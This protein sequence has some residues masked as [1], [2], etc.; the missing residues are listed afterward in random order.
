MKVSAQKIIASKEEGKALAALAQLTYSTEKHMCIHRHRHGRGFYY[1]KNGKK[2]SNKKVLERIKKLVIPPAWN[3]VQICISEK[4]HLQ[5]AGKDTKDRKVYLYHP[6]WMEL[7]N[8][9]KFFRMAAFGE[10]LPKIRRQV[11]KDLNLRGMPQR[12][13]LALVIRLMEETHIRIGNPEYASENGSFGLTTLRSRH[14]E[15][16]KNKITFEF[17]GKKGKQQ[18]VD[19]TDKKLVKLVNRCEE[20]PGWEVFKYFDDTHDKQTIDSGMVNNYIREIAGENFSAKDFRTWSGSILFFEHLLKLG[21]A[22]NEKLNRKNINEAV[23]VAAEAL[24]NTKSV[25]E[26]YYIHP[27][28]IRKYETGELKQEFQKVAKTRDNKYMSKTE[29]VLLAIYRDFE[30]KL[31]KTKA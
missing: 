14:L 4:G 12:K 26:N 9:T 31:E 21:P 6:L 17:I 13:V 8:Q 24:G 19:I 3:E 10:K 16:S 27:E 22:E 5:A 1:S 29:K 2:V 30:I 25:C 28:I 20:I 23:E 7:Q 18:R 11:E 15:S